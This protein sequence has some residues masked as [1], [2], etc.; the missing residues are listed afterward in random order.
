MPDYHSTTIDDA[1]RF[2]RMEEPRDDDRPTRLE[3]RA[4][5]EDAAREIPA[6]PRCVCGCPL[7]RINGWLLASCGRC[8]A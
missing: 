8:A 6:A 4:E 7:P 2:A 3:L 1:A 5:Y